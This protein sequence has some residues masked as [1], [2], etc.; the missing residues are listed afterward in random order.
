M[1]YQYYIQTI[2]T[3][4]FPVFVLVALLV[5]TAQQLALPLPS[6]VNNY[7]NDL[8]CMPIV[9]SICQY[10]VRFLKKNT[11][12]QIPV[13]L[14]VTLTLCYA[15]YFEWLLPQVN[16]RYTADGIDV[17]LYFLGALFFMGV[18]RYKSKETSILT[19][20]QKQQNLH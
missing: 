12:L 7:L 1:K 6:L 9:L 19:A 17:F 2:K 8:L 11:S 15:V 5:Y 18:A 3:Y 14:V 13:T 4:Y 16:P 20:H 10:A